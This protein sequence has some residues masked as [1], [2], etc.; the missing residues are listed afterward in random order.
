MRDPVLTDEMEQIA[1]SARKQR[2]GGFNT[3]SDAL[4][5]LIL[6]E[7]LARA[8]ASAHLKEQSDAN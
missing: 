6:I 8:L 2:E 7:R 3:E 1:D 4:F 5:A